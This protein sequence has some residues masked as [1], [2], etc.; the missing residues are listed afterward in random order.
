M[1]RTT[2]PSLIAGCLLVAVVSGCGDDDP[3][4]KFAKSASP[5]TIVT[6]SPT[7]IEPSP[8]KMPEAAK[9]HTV[10]GA[11]GFAVYLW[12]LLAYA[13]QHPDSSLLSPL[14]GAGC[15]SCQGMTG[16][17]S[18][19]ESGRGTIRGGTTQISHVTAHRLKTPTH[20]VLVE[21]DWHTRRQ[22]VDYPGTKK[23]HVNKASHGH[24]Q[25]FVR[26]TE[27]GWIVSD[28]HPGIS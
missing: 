9:K 28:W 20:T 2:L 19:L 5:S 25:L 23:D 18:D 12:H 4:P 26:P 22:V 24:D 14:I 7:P 13:Q 21:Y 16:L 1:R 17:I 3:K 8:P 10:A 11:E 15:T 6:S 27:D